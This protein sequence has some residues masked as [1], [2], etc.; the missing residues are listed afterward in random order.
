VTGMSST[1]LKVFRLF[2]VCKLALLQAY[3]LA[4][5]PAYTALQGTSSGKKAYT[6]DS[7]IWGMRNAL[8][9]VDESRARSAPTIW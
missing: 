6:G 3:G 5:Q 9:E 8:V 7:P 2:L 1:I 4:A